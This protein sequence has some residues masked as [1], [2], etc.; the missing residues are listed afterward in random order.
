MR[1]FAQ[2]AETGALLYVRAPLI[3][4]LTASLRLA[5]IVGVAFAAMAFT[6]GRADALAEF[7]PATVLPQFDRVAPATYEFHLAAMSSRT[8]TGFVRLQTSKG[9][10]NAVFQNVKLQQQPQRYLHD[11]NAMVLNDYISDPQYVQLPA[12]APII[13]GY[14]SQ[15][16]AT[17]DTLLGWDQ[18]GTVTCAPT[19]KQAKNAPKHSFDL[20]PPKTAPLQAHPIDS[21]F[22]AAC[23]KPFTPI[24]ITHL[25]PVEIPALL[26]SMT[27]SALPTGESIVAVALDRDGKVLDTWLWAS[28]GVDAYDKTTLKAARE[29]T[30]E[31]PHA[32]CE[33]IPSYYLFRVSF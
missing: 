19:G 28:S 14:V 8:V 7:C 31:P 26:S 9:W 23:K 10:Y 4:A 5:L 12:D 32:F 33:T 24:V 13:Y 21:P 22:A 15:A 18:E 25:Q 30:Y 1:V 3:G 16:S 27:Y 17:G 6:C 29:T 11:G 20:S 2:G